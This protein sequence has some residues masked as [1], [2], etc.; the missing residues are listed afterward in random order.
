MVERTLFEHGDGEELARSRAG[1]GLNP[2]AL[3]HRRGGLFSSA[4]SDPRVLLHLRRLG[5][6]GEARIDLRLANVR[7]R[8]IRALCTVLPAGVSRAG[9]PLELETRLRLR[10]R[11]VIQPITMR[12]EWRCLRDRNGEFTGI[13]PILRKP[14]TVRPGLAMRCG[15]CACRPRP[16]RRPSASRSPT[17]AARDP[18]RVVSSLWNLR[19]TA[20]AGGPPRSMR[21]RE[22]PARRSRT[23]RLTVR[24]PRGARRRACVQVAVSADSAGSVRA[25]RC[26]RRAGPV[27]FTG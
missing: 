13:R 26:V 19:I 23:V 24:L 8:D 15:R 11:G 18:V 25:R 9:R 16:A 2:F 4:R 12:Q 20:A 6:R 17:G 22:L 7:T 21:L 1:R 10:D 14:L 3:Q 5:A 27:R